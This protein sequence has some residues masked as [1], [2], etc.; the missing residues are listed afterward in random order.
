[1]SFEKLLVPLTRP[2][3]EG[4]WFPLNRFGETW[5]LLL[6]QGE[7]DMNQCRYSGLEGNAQC[8]TNSVQILHSSKQTAT[9]MTVKPSFD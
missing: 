8:I 5:E 4:T 1:M 3:S 6:W 9:T 7:I 2:Q